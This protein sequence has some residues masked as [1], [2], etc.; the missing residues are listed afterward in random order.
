MTH[1]VGSF[2][3]NILLF[4]LALA[5]IAGLYNLTNFAFHANAGKDDSYTINEFSKS[6]MTLSQIT[7]VLLWLQISLAVIGAIWSLSRM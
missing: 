2:I 1:N 6:K 7:V 3:I 5:S 4:M